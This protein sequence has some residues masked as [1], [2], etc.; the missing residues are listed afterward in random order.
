MFGKNPDTGKTEKYQKQWDDTPEVM[1]GKPSQ[2]EGVLFP[3]YTQPGAPAAQK[4]EPPGRFRDMIA[5]RRAAFL[6]SLQRNPQ[7]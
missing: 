6:A 7:V 4:K 2:L 3:A 5:K 1:P